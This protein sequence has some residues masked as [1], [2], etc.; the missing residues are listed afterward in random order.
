MTTLQ[1][2]APFLVAALAGAALTFFELLKT[3]QR[4]VG[5]ALRSRWGLALLGLN[6]LSAILV[7]AFVRYALNVDAGLW[8]ALAVGLTFPVLL[9]SRFTLYRQTGKKDDPDLTE[10]SLKLDEFYQTLQDWCYT[11]VNAWLAA[12]RYTQAEAIKEKYTVRQLE[13][14]LSD[15]IASEPMPAKRDEHEARLQSILT[16]YKDDPH[17]RHHELAVLYIDIS[18]PQE[19]HKLRH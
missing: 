18:T 11:E 4:A 15:L 17:R 10:I 7:Y 2:L 5:S 19:I 6:A 3:F 14:R 16:A 9:R 8:T 12:E 13:Q 1:A